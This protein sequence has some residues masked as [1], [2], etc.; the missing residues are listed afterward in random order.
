M[1]PLGYVLPARL[2]AH[3]AVR[4][5]GCCAKRLTQSGA[6][7]ACPRFVD[8]A[9]CYHYTTYNQLCTADCWSTWPMLLEPNLSLRTLN[10]RVLI[11]RLQKLPEAAASKV[12]PC[13]AHR[14]ACRKPIELISEWGALCARTLSTPNFVG[15]MAAAWRLRLLAS[16][17]VNPPLSST[18]KMALIKARHVQLQRGAAARRLCVTLHIL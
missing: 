13:R 5:A 14:A 8:Y 3:Q 12:R 18:A 16:E 2:P 11:R 1:Q 15:G 9:I 4:L 7:R 6:S 10:P 17:P